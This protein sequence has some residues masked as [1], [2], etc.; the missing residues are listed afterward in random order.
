MPLASVVLTPH[1]DGHSVWVT[2]KTDWMKEQRVLY[3][4]E[5]L[6]IDILR[7][8]PAQIGWPKEA[9]DGD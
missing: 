5:D 4:G 2:I 8:N 9:V 1:E 7:F 3:H 6:Q